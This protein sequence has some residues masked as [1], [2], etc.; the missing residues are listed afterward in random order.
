MWLIAKSGSFLHSAGGI[1]IFFSEKMAFKL[2]TK[3]TITLLDKEVTS[4]GG[5]SVLNKDILAQRARKLC[6]IEE[7]K[8]LSILPQSIGC[9]G[10]E[11]LKN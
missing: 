10:K 2:R 1:G 4:I 6:G 9:K 8:C 3:I 7:P 5:I 11:S